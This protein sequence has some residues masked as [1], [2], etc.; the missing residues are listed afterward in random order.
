MQGYIEKHKRV[1]K[2][3]LV[4]NKEAVEKKF[5]NLCE[6]V[7]NLSYNQTEEHMKPPKATP[8]NKDIYRFRPPHENTIRNYNMF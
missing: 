3:E 7:I 1:G 2:P 6:E 8:S 5:E 4:L